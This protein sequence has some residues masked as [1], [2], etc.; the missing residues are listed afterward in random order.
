M[1]SH[2]K[3][4]AFAITGITGQVGGVVAHALLAAGHTVRAVVR[5]AEKGKIWAEQGCEIALAEMNDGKALQVA[6]TGTDGV[7]V[8]LPPNFAP[9]PGFPETTA[10]VAELNK[11]LAAARP[12]RVVCLSTIGAQASQANLLTQLRIMEQVLG[13]LA[14][15]VAF[16]RA[17]WFMENAAWDVEPA[18]KTGVIPSFLQP[19]D[20]LFPM[21]ATADVGRV[22]AELLQE[23]WNGKKVV[24]LEGPRRVAPNDIGATFSQILGRSVKMEAVPREQWETL[25]KRQGM[26]DPTPRM[27]MLDGFNEGWIEFEGGEA[28]SVKGVIPLATVLKELVKRKK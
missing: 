8:L 19:L 10:I 26:T 14:M 7:F 25:F 17:A 23:E 20:K 21:V 22:A 6:F 28:G 11:A 27:R 5:S 9:S 13:L 1:K 12:G 2:G 3:R 4:Q 18:M 16:L 15:P 24:E